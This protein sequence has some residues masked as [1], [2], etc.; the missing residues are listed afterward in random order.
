MDRKSG[1][2]QW[3]RRWKKMFR[4]RHNGVDYIDKSLFRKSMRETPLKTLIVQCWTQKKWKCCANNGHNNEVISERMHYKALTSYLANT[5]IWTEI[6]WYNS[7]Q[8]LWFQQLYLVYLDLDFSEVI[9]LCIYLKSLCIRSIWKSMHLSEILTFLEWSCSP[10]PNGICYGKVTETI[11][12]SMGAIT[13]SRLVQ[14][15][16]WISNESQIN[17]SI[18][19]VLS[20]LRPPATCSDVEVL[21]VYSLCYSRDWTF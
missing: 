12:G 14:K 1:W 11:K 18:G 21:I 8:N 15:I 10:L 9:S 19:N 7:K 2:E 16:I 17:C 6:L 5:I 4:K 20:K 13:R 3:L